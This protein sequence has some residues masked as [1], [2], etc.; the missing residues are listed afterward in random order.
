MA[1]VQSQSCQDLVLAC[2]YAVP[3]TYC[4]PIGKGGAL[5]VYSLNDRSCKASLYRLNGPKGGSTSQCLVQIKSQPA[6]GHC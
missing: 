1:S 3:H 2:K 4:K 5:G 6:G